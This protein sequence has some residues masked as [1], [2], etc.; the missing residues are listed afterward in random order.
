MRAFS[1]ICCFIQ[2]GH[3]ILLSNYSSSIRSAALKN[4]RGVDLLGFCSASQIQVLFGI[5]EAVDVLY[6]VVSTPLALLHQA[7]AL[8]ILSTTY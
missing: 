8:S 1:C 4:L 6:S 7:P 3:L 5:S 2:Y